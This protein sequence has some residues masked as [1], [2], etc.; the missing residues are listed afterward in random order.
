MVH[1]VT[2]KLTYSAL[3]GTIEEMS[4]VFHHDLKMYGAGYELLQKD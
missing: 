1:I 3:L 4:L 2:A